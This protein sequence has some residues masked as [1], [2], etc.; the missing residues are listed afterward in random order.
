MERRNCL[1]SIEKV[2][3]LECDRRS[4]I[5]VYPIILRA[6]NITYKISRLVL[7]SSLDST[8]WKRSRISPAPCILACLYK[9]EQHRDLPCCSPFTRSTEQNLRG[10]PA[11]RSI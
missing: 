6:E 8:Y 4:G 2:A 9:E 11:A 3:G 1:G 5:G 7:G 10:F